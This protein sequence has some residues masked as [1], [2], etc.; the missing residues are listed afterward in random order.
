MILS[1]EEAV[2][3]TQGDIGAELVENTIR[4]AGVRNWPRPWLKPRNGVFPS[5]RPLKN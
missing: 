4:D 3:L 1:A 5:L 2:K